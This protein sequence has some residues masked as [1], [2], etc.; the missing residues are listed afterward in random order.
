MPY[1]QSSDRSN[2]YDAIVV[3]S[4]I[5]G[6]WAAKELTERGLQTLVLERGPDVQHGDYP[7]EHKAP[8]EM[9][10]NGQGNKQQMK[11]EQPRQSMAGPVNP[12][13]NHFFVNDTQHPYTFDEDTPF[14]WIRG[15]QK[16][17]RSL[18]WGRQTYRWSPMDFR[19]NAEEGVAVDWPIRYDDVAPWYSYVERYAGITGRE[20]N[21]PQ[22]PD[23]EFLPPMA[24]GT[25]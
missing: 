10:Y 4:G 16:G 19:A 6:G 1:V 3:G 24:S 9:P 13:N 7:T 23:S 14:L 2:H 8:W 17:G 20:E 11:E 5:S 12:Y 21:L 25:V 18:T 22:L 15:Y